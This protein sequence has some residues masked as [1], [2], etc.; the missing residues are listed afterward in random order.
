MGLDPLFSPS[1]VPPAQ[2]GHWGCPSAGFARRAARGRGG[3][4]CERRQILA[5]WGQLPGLAGKRRCYL[6]SAGSRVSRRECCVGKELLMH[7][8]WTSEQE[9]DGGKRTNEKKERGGREVERV[10][11]PPSS[12]R[13]GIFPCYAWTLCS[14]KPPKCPCPPRRCS[15]GPSA[16]LRAVPALWPL[17]GDRAPAALLLG[18]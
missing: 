7:Y 14:L 9:G 4:C 5:G 10:G 15:M 8:V 3:M 6:S 11:S 1:P 16:P 18:G 2:P 12:P 13:F 17:N